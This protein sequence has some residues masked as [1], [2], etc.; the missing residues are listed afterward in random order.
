MACGLMFLEAK[1]LSG[2]GVVPIH[3]FSFTIFS[4]T[5]CALLARPRSGGP[6]ILRRKGLGAGGGVGDLSSGSSSSRSSGLGLG[7]MSPMASRFFVTVSA[8]LKDGAVVSQ[9]LVLGFQRPVNR[10][11]SP[12]DQS[13]F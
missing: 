2:E 7:T 12:Q 9:L 6:T 3:D 13:H 1:A 11:E 10:I 8:Y 5:A 4:V